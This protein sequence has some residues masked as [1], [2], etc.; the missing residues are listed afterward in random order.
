MEQYQMAKGEKTFLLHN[1]PPCNVLPEMKRQEVYIHVMVLRFRWAS[2]LDVRSRVIGWVQRL[3]AEGSNGIS[4]SELGT[5]GLSLLLRFGVEG[6][7]QFI[8]PLV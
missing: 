7:M 3:P 1:S 2:S 5:G 8:T 6:W 4:C